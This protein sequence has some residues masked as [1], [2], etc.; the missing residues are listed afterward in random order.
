MWSYFLRGGFMMYPLFISSVLALGIIIERFYSFH[1]SKTNER[2]LMVK[3]REFL[4][5][6][7]P[8]GAIAFCNAAGGPVASILKAGLQI[9]SIMS[10]TSD[11]SGSAGT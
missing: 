7:D 10:G 11:I 6:R 2:Y 9:E 3:I 4:E 1:K 5:Q 8:E